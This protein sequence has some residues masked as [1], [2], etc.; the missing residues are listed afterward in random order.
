MI[1]HP[2]EERSSIGP[3]N[4]RKESQK[5]SIDLRPR[6]FHRQKKV[7][8]KLGQG[9]E[10]SNSYHPTPGPTRPK[11]SKQHASSHNKQ[12]SQQQVINQNINAPGAD[13]AQRR[14]NIVEGIA[15]EMFNQQSS[16]NNYQ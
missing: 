9:N 14:Q 7:S 8:G 1:R 6:R 16:I 12:C 13:T 10:D 5:R 3:G 2:A 15:F 4:A 11:K